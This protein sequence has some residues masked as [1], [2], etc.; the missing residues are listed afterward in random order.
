MFNSP[1]PSPNHKYHP[2]SF[3]HYLIILDTNHFHCDSKQSQICCIN[4][5]VDQN[6]YWMFEFGEFVSH[7]IWIFIC[8]F[9]LRNVIWYL[10]FIVYAY[11]STTNQCVCHCAELPIYCILVLVTITA[12]CNC[13]CSRTKQSP[14]HVILFI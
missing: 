3:L 14:S 9:G 2:F 4:D 6:V 12:M 1:T 8:D 13:Q 7:A 10:I 11:L 5:I